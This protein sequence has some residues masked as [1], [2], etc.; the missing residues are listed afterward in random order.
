MSGNFEKRPRCFPR[1]IRSSLNRSLKVI[2]KSSCNNDDDDDDGRYN[3]HT[4]KFI[5]LNETIQ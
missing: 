1:F 2:K 5:L 4:L 3:P